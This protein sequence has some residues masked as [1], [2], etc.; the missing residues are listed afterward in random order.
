MAR[1]GE[2]GVSKVKDIS[3]TYKRT[4]SCEVGDSS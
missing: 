1:K 4:I 2:F 3:I